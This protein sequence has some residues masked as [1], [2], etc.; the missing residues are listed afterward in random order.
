M[1]LKDLRRSLKKLNE[2]NKYIYD[3]ESKSDNQFNEVFTS[4]YDKKEYI[5]FLFDK[6][7]NKS[8]FD[9]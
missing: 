4:F 9:N 6:I 1:D 8:N 3:C 2:P 5:D 7:K